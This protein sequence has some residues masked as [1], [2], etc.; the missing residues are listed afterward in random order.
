MTER[1]LEICFFKYRIILQHLKYIY[2]QLKPNPFPDFS[3][4]V[5]L[6]R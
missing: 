2:S 1:A 5:K 4:H 3:N 6:T